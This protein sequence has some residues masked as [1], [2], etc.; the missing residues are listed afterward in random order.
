MQIKSIKRIEKKATVYDIT[1]DIDHSFKVFGCVLH[2]CLVCGEL[3]GKKFETLEE[4]PTLPQHHNC[5]CLYLPVIKGMEDFD[6]DDER[7]S[8]NG[9]VPANM[10]YE[11][12][13]K[14]QP[15]DVVRDIL[16]P[17]RF[18]LY[19]NGMPI[20]SFVANGS[21]L[22][23]QQLSEKEG[24]E[25]FSKESPAQELKIDTAVRD[26]LPA[27][28]NDSTWLK[29]LDNDTTQLSVNDYDRLIDMN[30]SSN[31]TDSEREKVRHI[32]K[33]HDE[34]MYK[35]TEKNSEN[36]KE[37]LEK[38]NLKVAISTSRLS[39]SRYLYIKNKDDD[40]YDDPYK[41][42]FSSH[43]SPSSSP[44]NIDYDVFDQSIIKISEKDV[45]EIKR[46]LSK[47]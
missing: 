8:V 36:F 2:N 9:P 40:I 19:Q 22:N 26:D 39:E 28:V 47:R 32:I 24:L 10:T 31:I 45:E 11:D 1:V 38:H 23:L 42:R 27:E 5:R 3:D 34:E 43:H 33:N 37:I 16:G 29:K 14:T 44:V 18:D 25:L 41:I 13:L 7:A 46:W 12:W 4:A 15:D 20:T 21:T 6:E 30:R 17:T 35:R